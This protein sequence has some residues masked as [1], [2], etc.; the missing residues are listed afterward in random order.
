ML[1]YL[2]INAI[3]SYTYSVPK[4]IYRMLLNQEAHLKVIHY[5]N[6]V[7]ATSTMNDER[8][9]RYLGVMFVGQPEVF[10]YHSLVR[11]R[12]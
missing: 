1:T 4:H 12:P 10:L 9:N 6:R 5:G 2:T 3:A 7:P 11:L 8:L